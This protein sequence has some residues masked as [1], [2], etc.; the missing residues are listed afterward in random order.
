[1]EKDKQ[2]LKNVAERLTYA[3]IKHIKKWMYCPACQDGKMVINKK[4]NMWICEDCGY[5]LSSDEFE[6]DYVFWFCDECNAYLNIQEGFNRHC[7]KF[8]CQK[9]G[10]END[11]TSENIKGMC[12]E[13]GKILPDPDAHLCVD[14]KIKR[15]KARREKVGSILSGLFVLGVATATTV[16]SEIHNDDDDD[17]DVDDDCD[18]DE[19]YNYDYVTEDWLKTASEEE[20]YDTSE[21]IEDDLNE[22]DYDSDEY[23][24]LD[25]K[26]IDIV[27]AIASRF[28]LNLPPREHGWY[29]PN[30]E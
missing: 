17:D 15:K 12:E 9:C 11:L 23:L 3:Y 19:S 13:C 16:W 27:N 22:M 30:D 24:E 1:M 4:S 29:L 26:H 8:V 21:K 6:D 14:C 28:P 25:L 18:E 2:K 7:E 20:L 5:K 10:H